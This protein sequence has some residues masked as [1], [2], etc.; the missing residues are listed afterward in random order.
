[1]T[2]L[3]VIGLDGST[4]AAT[5]LAW[6]VAQ[7]SIVG[8][9]Q[10]VTAW[11]TPWWAVTAPVPGAVTAPPIDE[12]SDEARAIAEQ[13]LDRVDDDLYETAAVIHGSPGPALVRAAAHTDL[14]VVGTRGRGAIADSL[15]GS[16]ST[17]CVA[18]STVPVIVVP[19][20]ADTEVPIREAIVAI[21]G[22]E[23]S[24][25]ALSW[26][27]ENVPAGATITAVSAWNYAP[28]AGY[29][30]IPVDPEVIS[31]QTERVLSEA[32][33]TAT[34]RSGSDRPVTTEVI[35]GDPRTVLNER[36]SDADLLVMGARGHRGVVHMLVGSVTTAL[37]HRPPVPLAVIPPGDRVQPDDEPTGSEGVAS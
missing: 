4:G 2:R 7:R 28:Y 17:Y 21:D 34:A 32:V 3:S 22:S 12:L 19:N 36:A 25:E 30:A 13:M 9:M 18:H 37:A 31:E 23:Q 33:A 35:P 10:P 20:D 1:M 29:E 15:L 14:L 6:A 8:V 26:A 27:L 24:I 5:A 11:R 16:V